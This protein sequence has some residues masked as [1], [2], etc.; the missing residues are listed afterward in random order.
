MPS[1]SGAAPMTTEARL[2]P[3]KELSEQLQ[4][5]HWP[6]HIACPAVLGLDG[7][8]ISAQPSPGNDNVTELLSHA[9]TSAPQSL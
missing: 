3:W 5:V 4:E 8:A 9:G 7:G 2:G 1:T 6:R